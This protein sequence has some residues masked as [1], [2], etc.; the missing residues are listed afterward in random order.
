MLEWDPAFLVTTQVALSIG[1]RSHAR[2]RAE[3]AGEGALVVEA[4]IEGDGTDGAVVRDQFVA[5]CVQPLADE[6]THR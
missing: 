3:G 5:G 1:R 4:K 6:V 2:R